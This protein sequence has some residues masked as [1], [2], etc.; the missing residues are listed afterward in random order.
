MEYTGGAP[1]PSPSSSPTVDSKKDR[2]E[3]EYQRQVL[4]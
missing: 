3:L 4:A 2:D 1:P